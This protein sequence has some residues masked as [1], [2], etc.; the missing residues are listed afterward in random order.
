MKNILFMFASL[1]ALNAPQAQNIFV[2]TYKGI[3]NGDDVV[4]QLNSKNSN[5]LDG[6]MDDSQQHYT[7]EG[8][9]K[10]NLFVGTAK[11]NTLGL[12]FTL[13]GNINEKILAMNFTLQMD[14]PNNPPGIYVEF[15]KQNNSIFN[16]SKDAKSSAKPPTGAKLDPKVIGKWV[17]EN[18]YS[19]GSG[20]NY[21]GGTTV[22]TLI[23]NANG[24]LNDGGSR[25]IASGSYFGAD[26][27][28]SAEHTIDGVSWHTK[29]MHLFLVATENG[30]TETVDLGKYYIENGAMLITSNNGKKLLLRKSNQ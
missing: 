30:K 6:T 15:E 29:N 23:F 5:I 13:S 16:H 18:N 9:Y 19:S 12:T 4:L 21:F 2:G 14:M 10:G 27:G 26:T 17:E 3:I 20:S 24:T 25:S 7:V 28:Q 11:E 8:T 1:V 22:N